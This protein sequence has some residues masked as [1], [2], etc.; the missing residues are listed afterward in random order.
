VETLLVGT[1][2]TAA[3]GYAVWALTPRAT[4]RRWALRAAQALGGPD[5]GGW[6]GAGARICLRL[7]RSPVAGCGD[8]PAVRTTPPPER[9]SKD[10]D[11]R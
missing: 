4:R 2:V 9:A 7:A 3:A 8:C 6:R 1:I 11:G 5:Q 10:S